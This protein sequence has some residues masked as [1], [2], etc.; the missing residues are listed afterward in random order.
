M[1]F[2][3]A[4][5]LYAVEMVGLHVATETD[6]VIE[7]ETET[8]V[9]TETDVVIEIETE[10]DVVTEIEIETDIDVVTEIE[11]ETDIVVTA[12]DVVDS[13]INWL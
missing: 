1:Y 8:D 4:V 10:I 9:A 12:L 2:V 3:N 13:H 5:D 6:V 7:I 11:I